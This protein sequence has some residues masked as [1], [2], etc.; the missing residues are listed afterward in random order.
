M[1]LNIDMVSE[2]PIYEQ[3]CHQIIQAIAKGELTEGDELPSVRSL[4]SDI[5]VNLHTI[6]KAYNILKIKGF[7]VV[8]RRKGVV[9]NCFEQYKSHPEYLNLLKQQLERPIVEAVARGLTKD[10][11]QK[12]MMSLIDEVKG[13]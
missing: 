11:I 9:V 8:N 10:D 2:I 12:L 3:L 4:A 7:L 6:N 5:G 1:L 13:V